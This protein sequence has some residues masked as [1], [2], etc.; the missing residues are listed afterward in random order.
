[1]IGRVQPDAVLRTLAAELGHEIDDVLDAMFE[2][3]RRDVPGFAAL[4]R[5][6]LARALWDETRSLLA[7]VIAGLDGTGATPLEAPA[8]SR[9]V[10]RMAADL[11]VPIAPITA[12][13]RVGQSVLEEWMIAAVGRIAAGDIARTHALTAAHRFLFAYVQAIVPLVEEQYRRDRY[14]PMRSADQRRLQLVRRIL[15]GDPAAEA[16]L[17]YPL[18]D[19]HHVGVVLEGDGPQA[20]SGLVPAGDVAAVLWVPAPADTWWGWIATAERPAL[21]GLA[22]PARPT[23]VGEPLRG[24]AGFRRTHDQARRAF[25]VAQRT[26]G[27]ARFGDVGIE[28][29]ALADAPGAQELATAVLGPLA[30]AGARTATLRATV[31]AYLASGQNAAAAGAVLGVS[32]RTVA[33]RVRSAEDQLGFAVVSRSVDLGAAL[34]VHRLLSAGV[35]P[36]SIEERHAVEAS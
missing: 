10:V 1:M 30:G 5:P 11:A 7:G 36:Q 9:H 8:E 32:D 17:A 24:R 19:V 2:R 21:G 31:E 6:E 16:A 33:N 34:R 22:G 27:V 14:G 20:A 26:G 4:E 23:G 18:E 13:Y 15:T 28:T 35:R 25:A 29:L 3:M 12:A